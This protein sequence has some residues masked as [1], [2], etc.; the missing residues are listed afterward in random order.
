MRKK[1]FSKAMALTTAVLLGATTAACGSTGT[2]VDTSISSENATGTE[3]T[4]VASN[5]AAKEET[6]TSMYP[7][8]VEELGSGTVKWSEETTKDGWKQV[9]ND[10]GETLGYSS[11]SGVSLI[12][13]DGYAFKDLNQNGKLDAYE[14]WRLE[15]EVRA[16]DVAAQLPIEQIF[17]LM[18]H[19]DMGSIEADG[20]DASARS[21]EIFSEMM[22]TGTRS[23]L[24]RSVGRTDN[25]LVATWNN[26]A[27]ELAESLNLGIPV[28]ISSNPNMQYEDDLALACTFDPELIAQTFEDSAKMYRAIGVT[29][30]LGPQADMATEP[31]WNRIPGTFGEDPYLVKTLLNSAIS[32]LQSTYSEAGE[33]Q[34]WGSE[35]V[36]AMMK[37][38]PG[39]GTGESGRESHSESGKYAVYPG[40]GF[41]TALIPFVEGGLDLESDTSKAAG[42]MT[43]YSIA[44]SDTN[45][46]G[47]LVGSAFS[48][49]KLNLLRENYNYDGVI[50]SDWFILRD[51]TGP[52]GDLAT[53]WGY[54]DA[55]EAERLAAAI[56]AGLDQI[57]GANSAD[58]E[59]AYEIMLADI[60]QDATDERF[61]NAA[62]H[63]TL[64][65]LRVGLF[66]NPYVDTTTANETVTAIQNSDTAQSISDKTIVM[67]KNNANTISAEET[68]ENKEKVYIP[69]S[70]Q[71]GKWILPVDETTVSELYEVVTDSIAE[72]SG[73]TD[74]DG[75][76][77]YT[78]SDII[79]ASAAE[80]ADI[81]FALVIVNSPVNEGSEAKGY[82]HDNSTDEYFPISL[83]YGEYTADSAD[84]RKESIS[85]NM[86]ATESQDTY[87]A[88]T[89]YEKQN[90]SYYGQSSRITNQ[91][92]L[93]GI[94]YASENIPESAKL[95][96]CVNADRSMVVSEFEE[97]ADAIL[98]GFG[99][100]NNVFLDV[101]SGKVEPTGLLPLQMPASMEAVEAQLE[102]VP[103]DMECYVDSAGNTYDFGYGLNWSGVISDERTEQ[104]CI[105]PQLE[106]N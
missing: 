19:A 33:D 38:F 61:H 18:L 75:N 64:S 58:F 89:S 84:V 98:M 29:T 40:D 45:E 54:E 63:I 93:E 48:N 47:D 3:T 66:E 16:K 82:G 68:S 94:L 87:G 7:M 1:N 13:V 5:D 79:R 100:D 20:S 35:S 71:D 69:L 50:C 15:D 6:D 42:V 12:Q 26:S 46:Y 90:R 72:P 76:A 60:G 41:E 4:A 92:E 11:N 30:L 105:E 80:L 17:G 91:T 22:K 101:V 56:E 43:S 103:R 31:R 8:D 21:G 36:I 81:D 34:G 28:S 88:V 53:P 83:Q 44:Y 86:V 59:G 95:V 99:I 67:V 57:G 39:D 10:G 106:L 51:Y 23:T 77:T 102:D 25:K 52:D 78:E 65:Y 74:K 32:A 96:V 73:E 104:F 9:I 24:Q 70:Y 2:E 85:G 37:H 14:D 27:Q 49:Y 62:E 55:T 97:Q